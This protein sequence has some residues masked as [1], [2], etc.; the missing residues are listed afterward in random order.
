VRN[1]GEI[2]ALNAAPSAM[3]QRAGSHTTPRMKPMPNHAGQWRGASSLRGNGGGTD[4]AGD[5]SN[6]W[7]AAGR[8]KRSA[9]R[10][11]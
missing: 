2:A 9:S 10:R 11:K 7:I 1:S 8:E 5:D 4:M 6:Q 3:I